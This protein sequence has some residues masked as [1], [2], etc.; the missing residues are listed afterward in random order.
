MAAKEAFFKIGGAA[1]GQGYGT[2]A[3]RNGLK[4][5]LDPDALGA[6]VRGEKVS[7]TRS[8]PTFEEVAR[9]WYDNHLKAG[10]SEGPYKLQV[11]QQLEDHVFPLIGSRPIN[12]L[13]RREIVDA[14]RILWL[15]HNPTGSK[16]RGNIERIFDYAIDQALRDDNPAPPTRSMPKKQHHVEHFSA[17]PYERVAEFWKWLHERPRMGP[18]THV[19]I[20]QAV[21]LGKRTG[22]I[23]KMTWDQIDFVNGIWVTPA[24]NMKKRKAHRQPLPKQAIE[25]LQMLRDLSTVGEYVF[26]AGSGK[27]MSENAMLYAIKRFG[28]ITTHGFRATLGSWCA[29][30]GVNK[31]I[32][33]LIKSHQPKYLDAAYNRSDLLEDRRKV[34]QAWADF[35]TGSEGLPDVL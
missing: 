7:K 10:L 17:L 31:Q 13:K 21:L 19:G 25:K 6:V 18:H 16:V 4:L 33:D 8:T 12:E 35:V 14:I 3:I 1:D 30:T 27:P 26:D 28:D 22:E 5:T 2:Q 11:L 15:E 34:L 24:E 23:R 9:D 29:E 32:S 20:S